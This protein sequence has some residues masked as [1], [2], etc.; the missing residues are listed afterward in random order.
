M[1]AARHISGFH[2]H[3]DSVIVPPMNNT[4]A[5]LTVTE[6]AA[7]QLT[8]FVAQNGKHVRLAINPGGCSGFDLKFVAGEARPDD[9]RFGPA[10]AELLVDAMSLSLIA[11][12]TVDY[13]GQIGREG[14][15][16]EKIP[17]LESRCGCGS[18][19]NVAQ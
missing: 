3:S 17:K 18:S 5:P 8:A 14:F 7:R 4:S 10:G 9:L 16:V 2:S 6:D 11:G 19:F 13:V 1:T 15:V 12:A